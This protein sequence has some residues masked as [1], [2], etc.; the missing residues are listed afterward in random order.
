[1]NERYLLSELAID[2][3]FKNWIF[4]REYTI[5]SNH[6]VGNFTATCSQLYPNEAGFNHLYGYCIYIPTQQVTKSSCSL[7]PGIQNFI[8]RAYIEQFICFCL[9]YSLLI[10][11]IGVYVIL[12]NMLFLLNLNSH[13]TRMS[14]FC[15]KL[16]PFTTLISLR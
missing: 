13:D 1:M 11:V 10:N 6:H 2:F 14:L 16:Q 12:T 5:C 4:S 3:I 8:G 9:L 7:R 15:H